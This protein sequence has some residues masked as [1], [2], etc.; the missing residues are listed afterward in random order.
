MGRKKTATKQKVFS[1]LEVATICGV[2]NQTAINWIKGGFLKAFTTPGGQFRVYPDDLAVFMKSR[3]MNVGPE[4]SAYCTNAE[5]TEEKTI[6][7]VD[8]DKALNDTITDYLLEH[9]KGANVFQAFDGFE[10][11][12]LMA[13]ISPKLLVLDLNLPGIDG[14][15][16]CKK[17]NEDDS[18][19]HPVIVVVTALD[20][21]ETEKQCLEQGVKKVFH[22]PVDIA[23]LSQTI[24][25]NLN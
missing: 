5:N 17:I 1:A 22:K 24:E 4:V 25:V 16:L 14:L 12:N 21:K 23:L 20:D 15:G 18:F 11:G 19:G 13:K 3:R 8:D 10:A 6:L 9:L 2:V 7:V